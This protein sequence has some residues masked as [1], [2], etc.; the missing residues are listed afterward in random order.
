MGIT[1]SVDF[2]FGELPGAELHAELHRLREQA[3]VAEVSFGGGS[4]FL[5]S[6]HEQLAAAF[7][8]EQRFPPANAYRITIEPVQGV[9]FQTLEGDQHRL[10]RRLATP[11][12]RS[13]AVQRMETRGLA[14]IANELIDRLPGI[15]DAGERR[16]EFTRTF[17]HRY[18]FLV[19]SRMLG[20]PPDREEEFRGW[21]SGFLAFTQDA[22][23]AQ[24]C[25]AEITNYLKPVL[26]DRRRAPQDDVISGLVLADA[27]GHR[28]TDEEILSNI[29]LLF[30]AGA[31]TTTD[32]MGN[33]LYA[34]LADRSLWQRVCNEPAF[35]DQAIEELLRWETPVAILPRISAPVEIEFD[36]VRIPPNTFTLF[37]MAAANRDPAVFVDGDRFDPQRDSSQKLLSFGPGPRIC[38][39]MHLARKQLRVVLDVLVE[40]LPRLA[41][42]DVDAARPT[43]TVL[44][45]PRRLPINY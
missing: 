35:R 4:A 7:R 14:E 31:S 22:E 11:A 30:T 39:G 23:Y 38:P 36:G 6:G 16:C 25:A 28:L 5:I 42:E 12:F 41:L 18:A 3:P 33:L 17:T 27:D 8:D 43:G 29:R 44:R 20:I 34:L 19:I 45:G 9:T 15:A 40:R 32:A 37:A 2:A 1:G 24:H 13:T 10:Y 21:A 26:A